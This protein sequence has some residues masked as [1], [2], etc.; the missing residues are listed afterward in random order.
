MEFN[1]ESVDIKETEA[2]KITE[3]GFL[4]RNKSLNPCGEGACVYLTH[5]FNNIKPESIISMDDNTF[6]PSIN[7]DIEEIS[8]L[9]G[10]I[11]KYTGL[12][13][14][15]KISLLGDI[16]VYRISNV[17]IKLIRSQGLNDVFNFKKLGVK[18]SS[19]PVNSHV[20]VRFKKYD[21]VVN[22]Q[23]KNLTSDNKEQSLCFY[24]DK[25]WTS[26]DVD[27][28]IDSSLFFRYENI[29]WMES[30]Q[31]VAHFMG[32]QHK[33]HIKDV[34]TISIDNEIG[35]EEINVGDKRVDIFKR[36]DKDLLKKLENNILNDKF[37]LVKPNE[38]LPAIEMIKD[39]I[40]HAQNEILIFDSYLTEKN[41]YKWIHVIFQLLY[42][43][44]AEK[45]TLIFYSK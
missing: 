36:L 21:F 43:C 37:K 38:A 9:I 35:R 8:K 33:M 44:K 30:L 23:N 16:L 14:R 25:K 11:E 12:N 26:C 41:S 3:T 20:I 22:V 10:F 4:D 27:V 31:M 45:K 39:F 24:Y 6:E 40:L 18:I 19:L 13:L 2:L 1:V 42:L 28:Y 32:P 29:Y 5:Y 34:G 15:D 7:L 17:D